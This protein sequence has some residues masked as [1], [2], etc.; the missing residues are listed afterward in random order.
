MGY[1][2]DGSRQLLGYGLNTIRFKPNT[3]PAWA[4]DFTIATLV[5]KLQA[6]GQAEYLAFGISPF[7]EL[8]P[9]P[10]DD[11]FV[12]GAAELLWDLDL[13]SFY[14]FVGLAKKK[15][16][17]CAGQGVHL[18]DRFFCSP[19]LTAFQDFLI[20]MT[21]LGGSSAGQKIPPEILRMM[22]RASWRLV[23]ALASPCTSMGTRLFRQGRQGR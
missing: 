4:S 7:T 1:K 22:T 10:T 19:G 5:E 20:F 2:G 6:R 21:L 18:Q 15:A 16:H 17:H 13:N 11:S 9:H 14:S 12:R 23:S 3:N 8:A